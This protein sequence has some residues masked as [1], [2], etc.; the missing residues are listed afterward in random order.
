MKNK[1]D[2]KMSSQSWNDWKFQIHWN[3][4]EWVNTINGSEGKNIFCVSNRKFYV[5]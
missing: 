3:N 5:D 1:L 2:I 4:I